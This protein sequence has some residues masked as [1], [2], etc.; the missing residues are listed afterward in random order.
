MERTWWKYGWDVPETMHSVVINATIRVASEQQGETE[1]QSEENDSMFLAP[2]KVGTR[3]KDQFRHRFRR[4]LD[5]QHPA[6]T[7]K[8]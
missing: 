1:T 4:L 7:G 5:L 3:A 8:D 6:P 2:V